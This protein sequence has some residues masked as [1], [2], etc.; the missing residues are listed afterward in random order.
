ML[1]ILYVSLHT[2]VYLITERLLKMVAFIISTTAYRH[3]FDN[4]KIAQKVS[5]L[6]ECMTHC[7]Y[8]LIAEDEQHTSSLDFTSLVVLLY[9]DISNFTF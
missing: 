3:I 8:L 7:P 6:H 1:P 2:G 5:N 9:P 4:W